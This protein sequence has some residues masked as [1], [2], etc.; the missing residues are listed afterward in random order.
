MAPTATDWEP[1]PFT[2]GGAD[3][4]Q[5]VAGPS[6]I[7]KAE[8]PALDALA[9]WEALGAESA[10]VPSP[11]LV[12]PSAPVPSRAVARL[13]SRAPDVRSNTSLQG[14]IEAH[15]TVTARYNRTPIE[16]RAAAAPPLV[17]RKQ[18]N[19][20]REEYRINVCFYFPQVKLERF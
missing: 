10:P 16:Y 1:V 18:A 12:A 11:A 19:A 8:A 9:F 13:R 4:E 3:L 15:A 2:L 6:R 14:P 7:A 17:G 5:P 20:L